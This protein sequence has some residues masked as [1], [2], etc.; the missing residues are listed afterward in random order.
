MMRARF[1]MACFALGALSTF[2]ASGC[3][4]PFVVEPAPG[5]VVLKDQASYEWRATTTEGV[6]VGV[7][8]VDDED[9]GDLGFWTSAVTGQLRD[10]SGYALLESSEIV[11]RDGTKGRLLKFGHD[12]GENKPYAYWLALYLAQGR[13]FLIDAG[14]EKEAFER[15]RPNVEWTLASVR[16]QCPGFLSPLFSSRTCHR[17]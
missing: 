7:R 11:S 5:F 13:I 16:V 12:E 6:V 3:G 17:W 8:V 1:A 2:G 14:G 9:R 15:A 10:V 4:K